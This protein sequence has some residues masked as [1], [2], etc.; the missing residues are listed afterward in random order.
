M[1]E[2]DVSLQEA[3]DI[4]TEML[5]Q[6]VDDYIKIKS[7]LPSF[8]TDV[9]VVLERYFHAMENFVQGLHCGITSARVSV[10]PHLLDSKL[11]VV[12]CTGFFRGIDATNRENLVVTLSRKEQS[13]AW[14]S[15]D[16]SFIL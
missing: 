16:I 1:Q 7:Q 3:I 9:D 15:M 4:L 8:G 5:N 13:N 10:E 11:D 6:R 2:R 14:P 12:C